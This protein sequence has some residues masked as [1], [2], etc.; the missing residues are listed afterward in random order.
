MTHCTNVVDSRPCRIKRHVITGEPLLSAPARVSR[1][2]AFGE[3]NQERCPFCPSNEDDTPPEIARV[4]DDDRW[5]ARVFPNKYPPIDGAEVIVEAPEHGD[6]FEDVAHAEDVVRLYI[7]RYRT[8][9]DAAYTSIFKNQGTRAGSSIAHV[10]SQVI[11][12]SFVPPRIAR[13]IEAF[14]R[15]AKCPLC[16]GDGAVIREFDAFTWLTPSSSS[17]PYQQWIVP[18]RHVAEISALTDDEIAQLALLLREAAG[19]TS[20]VAAAFNW[21]LMTFPR[22]AI[23]HAYVDITPRMTTIAGFELGTGTFVEIIDP[24]AAAEVL[25]R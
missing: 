8:H 16:N 12:L 17:F 11:P 10:H 19:A 18:K 4:A 15:A 23:A 3:H 14:A 22:A 13:E 2:N 9:A 5:R 20:R 6:R 7:D 1:P 24:A 25:R 21:A